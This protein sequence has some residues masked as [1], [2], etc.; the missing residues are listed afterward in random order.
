MRKS[1][2]QPSIP[3]WPYLL[4]SFFLILS[5][6]Q[7]KAAP[8]SSSQGE[9]RLQAYDQHK[10]MQGDSDYA[11]EKWTFFGPAWMSGRVTDVAIPRGSNDIIYAAAA[12]GGVWKSYDQGKTW[13]AVFE[14]AAST[15]I[16]DIA[17]AP[18]DTNIIWVATG[19]ANIF[20]SS[21]AGTGIYKS[22]DAGKTWEHMG[23]NATNTVGR[24]IVHPENPD[25]VYVA[26]S[27]NEWT[28]N[29]Q[30]GVYKTTDGGASWEKIFYINPRIGAIDLVM[31][32]EDPQ[33]LYASMW[34]RIRKRWSDPVPQPGDGI[35]KTTNA[36]KSWRKLTEGLPEDSL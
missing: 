6:C 8:G 34:H 25:I 1:A 28:T 14:H 33:I 36:G 17:I 9:K 16:G 20:R 5:G 35:F 26:A 31:D 2:F 11:G 29:P 15:S 12:S 30:R 4:L 27:G 21:M 23:L 24:I 13:K 19:E 22:I 3:G 10:K 32:P 7:Y 18:S